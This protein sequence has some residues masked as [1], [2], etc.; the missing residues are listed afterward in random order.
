MKNKEESNKNRI[1]LLNFF[2][3]SIVRKDEIT[4]FFGIFFSLIAGK[5]KSVWNI[6][7]IIMMIVGL[8]IILNSTNNI[9]RKMPKDR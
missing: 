6:P 5:I 2:K 8:I 4:L 3:S 9:I 1:S 7:G